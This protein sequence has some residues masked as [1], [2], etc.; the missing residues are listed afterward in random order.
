M[1]PYEGEGWEV[2]V[3]A[4]DISQYDKRGV[5]GLARRVTEAYL[6]SASVHARLLMERY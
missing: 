4:V 2:E 5:A 3:E 1:D 6:E